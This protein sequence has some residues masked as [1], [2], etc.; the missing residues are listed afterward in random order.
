M[1]HFS[2]N[3]FYPLDIWWSLHS[4]E[5]DSSQSHVKVSPPLECL[6]AATVLRFAGIFFVC[7]EFFTIFCILLYDHSMHAIR[8]PQNTSRSSISECLDSSRLTSNFLCPLHSISHCRNTLNTNKFEVIVSVRMCI[9]L[10]SV[11]LMFWGGGVKNSRN[12]PSLPKSSHYRFPWH[13]TLQ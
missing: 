3:I 1:F 11:L 4:V 12:F 6:G 2:E 10:G 5:C 9:I 13:P 7:I 8:D